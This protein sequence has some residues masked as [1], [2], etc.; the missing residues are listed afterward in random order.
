MGRCE[1]Q[2]PNHILMTLFIVRDWNDLYENNRSRELR[3]LLWVPVPTKQDGD[4]YTDMVAMQDGAGLYGCWIGIVIVA[5]K[6]VPRGTLIR[7]T[8]HPHTA[9]SIARVS[10][11]PEAL[12]A[13]TLSVAVGIRWLD[14]VPYEYPA[15]GCGI[16]AV[17]PHEGAV[18][19]LPFLSVPS[20]SEGGA[21]E[22][23]PEKSPKPKPTLEEIRLYCA[24]SGISASDA[25]W[26]FCKC[27]GNGW[28]NGGKPIKQWGMTLLSWKHAGYLPSQ[29]QTYGNRQ[30]RSGAGE[31]P[32][33][34]GIVKGP[35]DYAAAARRKA[36]LGEKKEV[37]GPGDQPESA[38]SATKDA[39]EFSL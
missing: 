12:M 2:E 39:G 6:C 38:P 28:M 26:F 3:N 23:K 20:S 4:G 27:E 32:R 7:E 8:G 18:A 36:G 35:T 34:A 29:K 10:H 11:L 1:C 16:S 17:I 33:N 15:G 21:G 31:N 5:A 25:E 9:Q 22:T 14:S 37:A 19:S 13:R 24:K 30:H